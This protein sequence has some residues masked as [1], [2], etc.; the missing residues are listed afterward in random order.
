MCLT[1]PTSSK[2]VTVTRNCPCRQSTAAVSPSLFFFSE[3]KPFDCYRDLISRRLWTIISSDFFCILLPLRGYIVFA[4]F[5][6]VGEGKDEFRSRYWL[7]RIYYTRIFIWSLTIKYQVS[8]NQGPFT[9]PTFMSVR[10]TRLSSRTCMRSEASKQ[11]NTK[12]YPPT[13]LHPPKI[14]RDSYQ[15]FY[16]FLCI[17][18]FGR[19]SAPCPSSLPVPYPSPHNYFPE[20]Q[21]RQ[22][23]GNDSFRRTHNSRPIFVGLIYKNTQNW[24]WRRPTIHQAR[25]RLT[26]GGGCATANHPT[27]RDEVPIAAAAT[28]T[29]RRETRHDHQPDD[30]GALYPPLVRAP[31][32]GPNRH[33]LDA[34]RG[35]AA[36]PHARARAHQLRHPP[37]AREPSPFRPS[38]WQPPPT[39]TPL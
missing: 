6:L 30:D 16:L 19:R 37:I 7:L 28:T 24:P 33:L 12:L 27:R 22:D 9:C 10:R 39:A 4:C 5:D 29:P 20:P 31:A 21:M 14:I 15:E 1:T 23:T 26:S 36:Q 35:G 34:P 32:R 2:C 11:H 25:R 8:Q 17:S 13:A 18:P 3:Q 38:L